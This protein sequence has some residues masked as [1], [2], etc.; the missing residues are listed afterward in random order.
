M[1]VGFIGTGAISEAII[2]GLLKARNYPGQ[3]LV[4]RRSDKRSAKLANNFPNISIYEENQSLVDN[5]DMVIIAVLPEQ[6]EAVLKQLHFRPEQTIISLVSGMKLSMLA[7]LLS[8]ATNIHRA[9]PMPPVEIGKGPIPVCPP[10]REAESFFQRIGEVIPV[11]DEAHFRTFAAGSAVMATFFRWVADNA[12][13]MAAQGVPEDQAALYSASLSEA[14]ANLT[15]AAD[16]QQLQ[17]LSQECLT[18]G[19]LNEQVLTELEKQGWFAA[20][21]TA[22]DGIMHRLEN[23]GSKK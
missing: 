23:S 18:P 2:S 20:M 10:G 16:P 12:A 21:N 4:T 7:P 11:N 22:L 9:V 19:G 1:T 5:S 14:L 15:L 13:W 6:C 8:P 17:A 3:I